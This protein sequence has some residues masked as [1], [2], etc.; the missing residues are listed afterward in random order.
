MCRWLAYVGKP[1]SVE[2]LVYGGAHSLSHLALHSFEARLGVQGDGGGLGWYNHLPDP[3]L[4]RNSGPAWADPNLREISR[5]VESRITFAHIRASSGAPDLFVNCH[6]FRHGP[7][8]FMHNGQ[9]GGFA[10]LRRDLLGLLTDQAFAALQG[11]TDSE[12]ILQLMVSHGL[13]RDPATALRDV[14]QMIEARRQA[15]GIE[16]PFNAT[17]ALTDGWRFW[18]VRWASDG[19]PPTLYRTE[20]EDYV[21]LVSEPLDEDVSR[22]TEVPPNSLVSLQLAPDWSRAARSETFLD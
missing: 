2:G 5:H 15:A 4:Y 16:V 10:A 9:I 1:R 18:A 7:W 17:F 14:T 20:G 8:L 3:G 6:P 13:D 21:L 22:W 12:L 11:G 19:Q